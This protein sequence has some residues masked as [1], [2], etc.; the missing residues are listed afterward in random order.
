MRT[1]PP[2]ESAYP[3][4][5]QRRGKQEQRPGCSGASGGECDGEG[6]RKDSVD[7]TVKVGDGRST[8]RQRRQP[9]TADVQDGGATRTGPALPACTSPPSRSATAPPVV[10]T[11][12]GQGGVQS[13]P[14]GMP[15]PRELDYE[16]DLGSGGF[17]LRV[18]RYNSRVFA[19][20]RGQW[21]GL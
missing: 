18:G 10:S 2:W 14:A 16:R 1:Q 3:S 20:R 19:T 21:K 9:P 15:Q 13:S 17:A 11:T 12:G 6:E 8:K 7:G 4:D 5:G